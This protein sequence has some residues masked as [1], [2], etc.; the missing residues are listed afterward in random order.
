M[1]LQSVKAWP[2]PDASSCVR[3][4]NKSDEA[5]W[6]EALRKSKKYAVIAIPR[7]WEDKE[8]FYH[9]ESVYER[10]MLVT[11]PRTIAF[12]EENNMAFFSGVKIVKIERVSI[13]QNG[14][15]DTCDCTIIDE[16][17]IDNDSRPLRACVDVI[18]R[19]IEEFRKFPDVSIMTPDLTMSLKFKYSPSIRVNVLSSSFPMTI[20]DRIGL[21]ECDGVL[22]RAKK[23]LLELKGQIAYLKEMKRM[24]DLTQSQLSESQRQ[25]FLRQQMALIQNELGEGS[26]EDVE[27]IGQR[28][29]K[30]KMPFEVRERCYKELNKLRRINEQT[31]DYS[32][33]FNYLTTIS[34]LPW[35]VVS[36]D[37][38]NLKKARTILDRDHFGLEKVKERILE[39]LAVLKMRGDMKSP[40]L[41]LYGPPGVGKTSLGKSIATALNREYVR[42]SLGGLHDEAEIRGHRRTYIGA[43]P[44]RI[45]TALQKAGTDNPVILLDEIDKLATD[46]RS[47]P[48]AAMLEVLDPEQNKSFHDNYIDLDY[49]LS[50]VFFIAT[51][52]NLSTIAAPLRD[53]MEIIDLNGYILEEKVEIGERHLLPK[54]KEEHGLKD[55]KFNIPRPTMEAIIDRYTRESGVRLLDK[56]IA[57]IMRK[58]AWKVGNDEPVPARL[59]PNDLEEYLGK[60][61]YNPER[62]E[63]NEY[64]GVVTG[65]AWT[66]V[67]GEIL[68]V[69]SALIKG[70]GEKLTLT[71]NLG[72][73]MKE[74]A[75]LAMQY[76]RANA[77]ELQIPEELFTTYNV[78][79]H[80]PEGAIPKDGPSAGITMVT[81][82]AS[83]FTQR[84]VREK[85]AMTGEITLRG[86]VTPIG[87]VKEK[88]LA[89]KRAGITDL[90]LCIDNKKDVDEIKATYLEGLTFHYVRDVREVLDFALLPEKVRHPKSF[91]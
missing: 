39:H 27:I 51:A 15:F 2:F 12:D 57:K 33:Q 72:D 56:T 5:K 21:L 77:D 55:V 24:T 4:G 8:E 50:K 76:I 69:E 84:K 78:H 37:S 48:S 53:R 67:G 88:I 30:K 6:I 80:C 19:T 11:A 46:S 35:G 52:N 81:S 32:V 45:I 18:T 58:V 25:H 87:G 40:I 64:A 75:Q 71:G 59:A 62:Y 86:R 68:L 73:V 47:D 49:D 17:K 82:L 29:M 43:M 63:G 10:G 41:C 26:S 31:P 83:A 1:M 9:S 61:N 42:I 65:L 44:G 91:L 54:Q 90:V 36:R 13:G 7:Q 20:E 74:S 23:L 60:P 16:P 85:I 79:I 89:A 3:Y 14:E 34:E 28:L 38:N 22:E 66:S 70:K